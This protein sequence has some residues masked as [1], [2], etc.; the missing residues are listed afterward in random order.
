MVCYLATLL[1]CCL[2]SCL[3][4]VEGEKKVPNPC[5]LFYPPE[6]SLTSSASRRQKASKSS[7]TALRFS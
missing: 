6:I 3:Y 2:V 7:S 5:K 4:D 1:H